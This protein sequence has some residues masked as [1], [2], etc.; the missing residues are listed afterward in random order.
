MTM[1]EPLNVSLEVA[2]M[3]EAQMKSKGFLMKPFFV[4]SAAKSRPQ[5]FPFAFDP[6]MIVSCDCF[7]PEASI[8][9]KAGAG[10]DVSRAGH[11]SANLSM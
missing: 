3:A 2:R 7:A 4:L 1:C 10:A 5:P 11:G 8:K 6:A 9:R